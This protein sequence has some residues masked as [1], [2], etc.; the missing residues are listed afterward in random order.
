MSGQVDYGLITDAVDDGVYTTGDAPSRTDRVFKNIRVCLESRLGEIAT[1]IPSIQYENT[2]FDLSDIDKSSSSV[3]WIRATLLPAETQ[4]ASIGQNG[5]DLH[6]GIF[7]IDYFS[8]VGAGGFEDD[9]DIIANYFVKGDTLT[10]G[11][12]NVRIRNTSLGV[13]RRDG[14]FFVRNIDVDY[15]AYTPARS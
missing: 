13:G 8:S 2:E 15:F 1:D 11:T 5:R 3:K 7:Q 4:I 10:T 6:T 9:M 12:T 14:A